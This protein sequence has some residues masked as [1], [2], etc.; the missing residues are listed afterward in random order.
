MR[1]KEKQWDKY[2][3]IVKYRYT[4]T[5]TSM[6]FIYKWIKFLRER[7]RDKERQI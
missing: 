7:K 1:D 4:C 5:T 2:Q 3:V 6:D